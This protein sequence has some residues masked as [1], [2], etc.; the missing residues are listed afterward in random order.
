M[1]TGDVVAREELLESVVSL[2]YRREHRVEHRGEVAVRGGI[3]DVWGSTA[4]APVRIDL[5]GDEVERLCPFDPG[6]QRQVARCDE[7]WLFSCRELVPDDDD[8]ALAARLELEPS[9]WGASPRSR[10]SPTAS[11]STGWR[12]GSA[13]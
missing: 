11:S 3:V 7:V 1:R 4:D 2:G 13:G 5:F 10:A 6:D 9:P 12:G 8:R